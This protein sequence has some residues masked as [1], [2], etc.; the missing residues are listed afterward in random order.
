[1]P[2]LADII[3]DALEEMQPGLDAMRKAM[4]CPPA[5][6][7]LQDDGKEPHLELVN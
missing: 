4:G 1:M 6:W 2:D 5:R 3:F 7:V